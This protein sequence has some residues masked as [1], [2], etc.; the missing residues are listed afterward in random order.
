M[1]QPHQL[2][3]ADTTHVLHAFA[4]VHP[5]LLRSELVGANL[6]MPAFGGSSQRRVAERFGASLEPDTAGTSVFPEGRI[7]GSRDGMEASAMLQNIVAQGGSLP[8]DAIPLKR[9]S[10]GPTQLTSSPLTSHPTFR[11]RR[12]TS[13]SPTPR[14]HHPPAPQEFSLTQLPDSFLP[15]PQALAQH[16]LFERLLPE[17]TQALRAGVSPEELSRVAAALFACGAVGYRDPDF[18]SLASRATHKHLRQL[19][20]TD[21]VRALW[22]FAMVQWRDTGLLEAVASQLRGRCLPPE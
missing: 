12:A 5:K 21:L 9:A 18:L 10:D 6:S 1:K 15:T 8:D 16:P 13:A 17:V 22:G 11:T 3:L 14:H 2:S 19:S 4:E 7:R 20:D